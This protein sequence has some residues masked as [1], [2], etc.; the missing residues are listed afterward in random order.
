M[1]QYHYKVG[2]DVSHGA[3][4][5]AVAEKVWGPAERRG[6][7]GSEVKT[8]SSFTDMNIDHHHTTSTRHAAIFDR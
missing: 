3:T 2:C 7:A 4:S 6:P 1:V 5:L 8:V